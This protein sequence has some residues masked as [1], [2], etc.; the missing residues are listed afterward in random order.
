VE[1]AVGRTLTKRRSPANFCCVAKLL[2]DD[3]VGEGEHARRDFEAERL[4]GLEID[5]KR[6]PVGPL[7]REVAG[8]CTLEDAM[9]V[10]SRH[11]AAVRRQPQGLAATFSASDDRRLALERGGPPGPRPVPGDRRLFG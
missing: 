5:A 2:L 3:L 8:L 4:G 6:V 10:L 1:G 11:V 7:D 9:S